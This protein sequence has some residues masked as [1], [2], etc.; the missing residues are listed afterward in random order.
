MLTY[1][2]LRKFLKIPENLPLIL[3]LSMLYTTVSFSNTVGSTYDNFNPT[4]SGL[5]YVTVRSSRVLEAGHFSLGLFTDYATNTLPYFKDQTTTRNDINKGYNDGIASMNFSV[6][7][8]IT[9]DWEI[10]LNLPSIISQQVNDQDSY[11]GQFAKN[12]I[13]AYS[14]STKYNLWHNDKTGVAIVGTVDMNRVH[15][16]PLNGVNSGPSYSALFVADTKISDFTIAGNLGYMIKNPGQVVPAKDG[17]T[18]VMPVKNE[19]LAS[20][21]VQYSIPNTKFDIVWEMYGNSPQNSDVMD[22]STRVP[23]VFETIGGAK[24]HFD[25]GMI[26]HAG[27]GT[28]IYHSTNSPNYRAYAGIYWVIDKKEETKKEPPYTRQLPP[29]VPPLVREPDE[30]ITVQDV[31]FAFDKYT[32]SHVAAQKNLKKLGELLKKKPLETLVID[33]HTC[34][35]GSAQYNYKLSL[36]RANAIKGFIVKE[37]NIPSSKI[38]VHGYGLSRP[39]ESNKTSEGR[40]AN[41]RTE[42]KIYYQK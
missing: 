28:E 14:L 33:G 30:K 31:I 27:I 6:G 9:N 26:A 19:I 4:S 13:T 12:G 11:H 2:N 18:P 10:G 41:R 22:L 5:D 25:N 21:A 16:D 32:I 38:I 42:F 24:Y 37:Y 7:F 1:E 17:S 39:I 29:P 8:G 3:S 36:R 15:D 20:T 35:I 34:S 40:R 23:N